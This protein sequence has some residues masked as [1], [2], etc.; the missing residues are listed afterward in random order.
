L[1]EFILKKATVI[2][3]RG[4]HAVHMWDVG[5]HTADAI[6]GVE[7]L[8][9]RFGFPFLGILAAIEVAAAIIMMIKGYLAKYQSCWDKLSITLRFFLIFIR[10]GFTVLTWLEYQIEYRRGRDWVSTGLIS[11]HVF[12][13]YRGPFGDSLGNPPRGL[14]RD[15]FEDVSLVPCNS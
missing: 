6:S 3:I 13:S 7:K 9:M 15:V 11:T 1:A 4:T 2:G 12:I 8:Y 14:L 5:S 10:M